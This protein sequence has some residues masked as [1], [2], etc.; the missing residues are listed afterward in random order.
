MEVNIDYINKF[1]LL[2]KIRLKTKPSLRISNPGPDDET[3]FNQLNHM[4]SVFSSTRI[5][6]AIQVNK[7]NIEKKIIK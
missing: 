7:K 2:Y 1:F 4:Q 3:T 6:T 5:T